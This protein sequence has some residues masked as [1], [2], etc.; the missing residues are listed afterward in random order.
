MKLH[1]A[2]RWLP[3]MLIVLLLTVAAGCAAPVSP[4]TAAIAPAAGAAAQAAAVPLKAG[5]LPG[6]LSVDAAKSQRDAGAFILDVREPEEWDQFHLPG[7]TLIPLKQLP[8]R[9]SEIPKDKDVVVVCRSGNRSQAGRDILTAA[10]Y[11]SVASMAG[12]LLQWRQKGYP[13]VTGR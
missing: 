6:E 10:G 3:L 7:S 4:P 5:P 8:Q 2:P 9:L 13:T 12:G 1:V 11:K